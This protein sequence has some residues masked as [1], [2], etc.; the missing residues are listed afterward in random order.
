[1]DG[2]ARRTEQK[3]RAIMEATSEILLRKGSTHLKIEEIAKKANVSQ[4]TIYNYFGSKKKLVRTVFKQHLNER[5]NIYKQL[6][7]EER[8][9]PEILRT[10]MM[11]R[12]NYSNM[13]TGEELTEI[14]E[15]DSELKEFF[16]DLYHAKTIPLLLQFIQKGKEE[17]HIRNEISNE[18][19]LFYLDAMKT[20]I[21][22]NMHE[23][24]NRPNIEELSDQLFD[25]FFYGILNERKKVE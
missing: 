4:V 11:E 18:A 19:V 16:E 22:Q 24:M 17:G 13:L 12:K 5:L 3:K 2:F 6:V 10:I 7:S 8:P 23:L 15:E 1:M 9:F 21:D 20:I 14:Y 25:M